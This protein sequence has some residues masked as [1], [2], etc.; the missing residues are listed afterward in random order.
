MA[1]NLI[2]PRSVANFDDDEAKLSF[3]MLILICSN[4]SLE[5]TVAVRAVAAREGDNRAPLV[6]GGCL[7]CALA[8]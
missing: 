8:R 1:A 6:G 4:R 2:W 7:F 3:E 5:T